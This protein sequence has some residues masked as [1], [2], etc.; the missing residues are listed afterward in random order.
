MDRVRHSIRELRR[1]AQEVLRAQGFDRDPITDT[2][3]RSDP[4]SSDDRG[5]LP[6]GWGVEMMLD[7][8]RELLEVVEVLIEHPSDDIEIDLD[9]IVHEHV[10]ESCD[11]PK[12]GTEGGCS[13]LVSIRRSIAEA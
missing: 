2:P 8:A 6:S 9:V 3:S 4:E 1:S 11:A 13:T 5:R 10:A 7:Q 12:S